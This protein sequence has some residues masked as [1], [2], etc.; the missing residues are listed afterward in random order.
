M[1]MNDNKQRNIKS[2]RLMTAK[3]VQAE[4]LNMDIRKLR[5]FLNEFCT[6]RKIGKTYFYSRA[7]VEKLLLDENSSTEFQLIAY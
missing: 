3:E 7:E 4:Y 5:C 2:C 1:P 6:Y